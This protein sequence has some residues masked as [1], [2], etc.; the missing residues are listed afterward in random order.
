MLKLRFKEISPSLTIIEMRSVLIYYFF[1]SIELIDFIEWQ[2]TMD[3]YLYVC[4]KE[5]I[6]D[7][8]TW[9]ELSDK[10]NE[11]KKLHDALFDRLRPSLLN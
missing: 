1:N 5:Y 3:L 6:A 2:N 10:S 7:R 9:R 11:V 8:L 4:Q